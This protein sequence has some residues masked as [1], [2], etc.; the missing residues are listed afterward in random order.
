MEY[1]CCR[2]LKIR[3]DTKDKALAE[4]LPDKQHIA[5]AGFRINDG[6]HFHG[7]RLCA[8]REKYGH[9]TAYILFSRTSC[10]G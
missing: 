4:A 8:H 5:W 3:K 9:N 2:F 10:L 7:I 1:F 6:G